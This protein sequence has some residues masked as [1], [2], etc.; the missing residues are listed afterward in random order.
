[1]MVETREW[2]R[3]LAEFYETEI[4]EAWGS[5]LYKEETWRFTPVD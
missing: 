5:V 1:M 3:S 2:Y 4:H